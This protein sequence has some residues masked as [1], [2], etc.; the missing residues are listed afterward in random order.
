MRFLALLG[1]GLLI[2]ALA[3]CG[4]SSSARSNQGSEASRPIRDSAKPPH[5]TLPPGPPPKELVVRDIRKGYGPAIPP[6]GGVRID[7]NFVALSYGTGKPYEVRWN[8]V[9]AFNIGFG[10]GIEIKGWEKGLVGMKAGGRRELRV[11]SRLA[12][13]EG[14]ILYVID[15]LAVDRPPFK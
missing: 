6:K 11:P 4:G 3:A 9:G 7:T 2:S 15:L 14:A 13:Q 1:V 10:P 8:P 12:Y 5:A